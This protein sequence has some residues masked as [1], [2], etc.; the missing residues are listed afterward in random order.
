MDSSLTSSVHR[1]LVSVYEIFTRKVLSPRVLRKFGDFGTRSKIYRPRALSGSLSNVHIGKETE[2]LP[3]SRIQ[4]FAS[5]EFVDPKI[6]IGDNCYFCYDVSLLAGAD[7]TIHNNVLIASRVLICSES[8]GMN[9][10]SDL[11]YMSQPLLGA[12]IEIGDNCWIGENVVVLSGVSIGEGCI[13][14]ASSV[15]TKDIPPFSIAVG[16][17]ARVVKVFDFKKHAWIKSA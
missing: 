12:P 3:N 16:S 2:I 14:G 5:N 1:C 15:V 9:P 10:E 8:H 11:P 17:P 7:I 13:V 6:V 4:L